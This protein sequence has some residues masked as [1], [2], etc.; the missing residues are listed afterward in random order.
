MAKS[1]ALVRAEA[2][3]KKLTKAIKASEKRIKT[4]ITKE[5]KAP[6]AQK[7]KKP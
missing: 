1:K 6:R 7:T 3:L 5:E 2:L 4:L